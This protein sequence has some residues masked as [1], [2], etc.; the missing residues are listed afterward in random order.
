MRSGLFE[1]AGFRV[2][3]SVS[4]ATL[5]APGFPANPVGWAAVLKGADLC[6]LDQSM[7]FIVDPLLGE[8]EMLGG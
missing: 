1:R 5:Y 4:S 8:K 6:F 2:G 3:E 7:F